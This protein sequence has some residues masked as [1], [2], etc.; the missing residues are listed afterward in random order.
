MAQADKV[1]LRVRTY[2]QQ[3]VEFALSGPK[4]NR[5]RGT[6]IWW[7]I[8]V[9]LLS[10]GSALSSIEWS[11]PRLIVGL[12]LAVV[13]AFIYYASESIIVEGCCVLHI[14]DSQHG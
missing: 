7:L 10:S 8:S 14:V 13:A 12:L 5:N 9:L 11:V 6:S 4:W 3:G 2:G 1:V